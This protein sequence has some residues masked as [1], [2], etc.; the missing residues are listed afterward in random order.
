MEK[1]YVQIYT[2]DGKGK[3]TAALGLA[4]RAAGR[5]LRVIIVQF[6]KGRDSGELRSLALLPGVRVYRTAKCG[7]F[8]ASMT[9]AEKAELRA[10]CHGI[11]DQIAGWLAGNE[12]DL[13]ILDE[14]M[15][16]IHCG[17]V[18]A[19]AFLRLLDARPDSMEIVLT[20][21]RAPQALID[22]ADLVTEMAPVKHYFDRGVPARKGI[23]Y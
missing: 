6:M 19:G 10:S 18:A 8:F 3:T 2:G 1:G 13:L 23:E 20:G 5:G 15:G 16:A 9:D 11:I 7:K 12:A 4:L 14:A 21:R 17:A 22:R